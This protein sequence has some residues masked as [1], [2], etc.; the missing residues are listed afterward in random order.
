MHSAR[1][2][3]LSLSSAAGAP[4]RRR[5]RRRSRS[6]FRRGLGRW[7]RRA[8]RLWRQL[9]AAP[10]PLRIAVIAAAVLAVFAAT[11]LVYQVMRKPTEMF[12]PVSGAL[13]KA[14][15]ETWA[16]YGPLFREYSTAT[17]TPELLAALAQVEG[18]GNPLARTYW[19]W[20]LTWDPFSIYRPASSAVGMYQMTD[21]AFAEAREA[22]IR[23][24]AVVEDCWFTGLYSR[25]WPSHA[26]QLAAVFLDRQVAPILAQRPRAAATEQQTQDLAALIHLCGAGPAKAFARRGFHL[27][28]GQRCGAH[29]AARYLAAVNAM[30]RQ[31]VRL[32]Q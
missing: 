20:R 10:R 30:K 25:V 4:S 15:A 29:D 8:L 24:H 11:N 13:A 5:R 7:R 28:P 23:D 6:A 21:A 27:L 17:I 19:R 22:C 16:E 3:A 12:F 9:Y 2:I 14:P 31:F 18:A 1:M 26:I 32:A